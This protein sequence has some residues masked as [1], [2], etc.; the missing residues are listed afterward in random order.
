MHVKRINDIIKLLL[1]KWA[2]IDI[3]NE[4]PLINAYWNGHY[5]IVKLLLSHLPQIIKSYE[6]T[7]NI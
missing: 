4:S 2:T 6:N 3:N 1:E 7:R 5:E